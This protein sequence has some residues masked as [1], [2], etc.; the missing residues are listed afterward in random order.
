MQYPRNVLQSVWDYLKKLEGDLL[1]RKTSLA[2]EDPFSDTSRLNDNASDDTEAAEQNG[3]AMSAAL[4]A[5][6]SDALKRVHSAMKRVDDGTYG[7][8]ANCG[9]MIDTDRLGVDPTAELCMSC[10]KKNAK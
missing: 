4:G 1:K 9:E 10:A 3:H 8:C 2:K 5:E 6:T 7:K